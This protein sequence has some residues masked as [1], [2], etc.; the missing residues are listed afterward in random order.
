MASKQADGNLLSHQISAILDECRLSYAVHPRKLKELSAL[1]SSPSSKP[2]FFASFSQTLKPLFDFSR[3]TAAAERIVRFVSIFVTRRDEKHAADCDA[4]LEDFLKFLLV[5]AGATNKNARFRSCQIISE[6]IM[7]LPDDAEVSNELWDEVIDCMKQRVEDKVPAVRTFAVRALARFA[8]DSENADI[9]DLFLEALLREQNAEVRKTIVLSMPASS[10]TS[11]AII[12]CTLDVSESVR[13]AAYCVLANKF[14]L[15]SL[16]IKL[17]TVIL[18]RGLADRSLPVTNECLKLMRDEWL[19][20]CCNGDPVVLLKYLDV[21]TYESVGEAVMEA[22][23][24]AGMVHIEDGQSIRQFL[25]SADEA[26]EGQCV[27]GIQLMEAEVTLYWRTVCRH[28]QVEAQVKGSD[29]ATTAGTEAAVYAAEAS[30]RNDLLERV[31]P[32]TISDYVEL[33]KAHLIAGPNYHFA[34]RQLLLLGTMLDFSDA[35]NRKVAG[36]FVQELLNRPLDHEVD[37][38]GNNV[39]IGDGINL[40]GD[41]D[42]AQAVSE[43]AKKV[44]ASVGEFEEVIVGAVEQ[45]ARPCRERAADFMQWMHCLAVTGL[46][47]ENIKSLRC[48]QGTAIEASELLHAIL[49][50]GAKHIH[51]DVQRIATRCLGLFG[52]VERKPS[53]E[54]VKQLRL[55]FANGLSP[56]S[57]M[58]SKALLDLVMWHGPQEVDRA[59]GLDLS[60]QTRD[61]KKCF[62]S[63]KLSDVNGDLTVEMLD[64]L[65]AGLDRDDCDDSMETDDHESVQAILGEGFAKILLL[66]ENYPTIPASLHP[67]LLGRLINLYFSNET[68]EL[69]RLKQCLSVFFEHYPALSGD[70]KKSISKAFIPAM[71][72]MWP[73]IYGNSGGAPVVVSAQRK[74]ATQASRF[75]LQMMQ[76]PLYPKESEEGQCNEK[77]PEGPDGS[78]E[79]SLDVESGEEGLAI[80]I[81]EEVVSCP[82]K[83]TAAGKSYMSALC[84]IVLLLNFRHSEQVAIKCMRGLLGHMVESI[85]ADKELVKELKRMAVRLKA[86]DEHPDEVVSQD[87][88]NL[89]FGMLGLDVNLDMDVSAAMPPTPAPRSTRP[90]PTRR[91]A[92]REASSSDEEASPVPVVPMTPLASGRSQR[93]SKTVAMSR[94]TAKRAPVHDDEDDEDEESDVTSDGT[95]EESD[96]EP[97]E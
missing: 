70:H 10:T 42:W 35:T 50:P 26:K 17:R 68:K 62:T 22:L 13:R 39:V 31:L 27:P 73:G 18:Q 87:Q 30:D 38:D 4:F 55:S 3:K 71:R 88:A 61:D 72:S 2:H 45:L 14:P 23:L 78:V 33:V 25:G 24:K 16:S 44:H 76:T 34:S 86:L 53:E 28:L 75:M 60:S 89:I 96:D 49:L 47:L 95:S 67:I 40:G 52:L 63:V 21:E 69:L 85:S 59:M 11:A 82:M 7:R 93:V 83:K 56:V 81:A 57:V 32:A 65:N 43:L 94:L 64:L 29:A 79:P 74:R 19:M 58:A 46:L 48:L 97:A 9:I 6:I 37:D 51:V 8:N 84:R 1:R 80:R 66:S 20:K 5:A 36:S 54:L 41:R 91:R 92:R 90:A 77:T 12:E 15:Q